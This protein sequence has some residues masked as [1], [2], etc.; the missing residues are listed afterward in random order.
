MAVL[1]QPQLEKLS[2]ID[3]SVRA[4]VRAWRRLTT[5]PGQRRAGP[6]ERTLVACSGGADSCAL[7]LALAAAAKPDRIVVGHIVHDLRSRQESLADRDAVRELA[8]QLG[9]DFAEGE[10]TVRG[11]LGGVGGVGGEATRN[12]EAAARTSRYRKLAELAIARQI[13]YVAVGH[14]A[15]DQIETVLMTLLRGTGG[16]GVRGMPA[17][18]PL[19]GRGGEKV[20][21]IRPMVN[22]P[23]ITHE[24]CRNICTR[25]GVPWQEDATNSDTSRLRSALRHQVVPILR[26]IRPDL[27][28][29]AAAAARHADGVA[30]LLKRE[31]ARIL[32][33]AEPDSRGLSWTRAKLQRQPAVAVGEAL[34][35]ARCKICGPK[36]ADQSGRRTIEAIVRAIRDRSTDPRVFP[37]GGAIVRVTARS[38]ELRRAVDIRPPDAQSPATLGTLPACF[39]ANSKTSPAAIPGPTR[40]VIASSPT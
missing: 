32:R 26:T 7:L 21:L 11:G 6:G 38:V 4:I 10:I 36:G 34:R 28:K 23:S 30:R 3:P 2:R 1:P 22:E 9:L 18:R 8:L 29:R 5:P 25:A 15:D 20:W 12:P 31:A 39:P 16:G 35:L 17:K 27:A 33:I 40:S 14:H 24:V 13:R 37:L 19:A